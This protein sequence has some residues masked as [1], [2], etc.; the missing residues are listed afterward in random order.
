VL[1]RLRELNLARREVVKK[2][3]EV[4]ALITLGIAV[5]TLL[6]G[7][8]VYQQATGHSIFSR[9]REPIA[10]TVGQQP[11]LPSPRPTNSVTRGE[12]NSLHYG[13]VSVD[14]VNVCLEKIHEGPRPY[15]S[16]QAGDTIPTGSLIA[17]DFS[18]VGKQWTDFPI[19]PICHYGDW[20]LFE[21]TAQYIAPCEGAY[22][23]IIP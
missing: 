17:T 2:K 18:R 8:N 3:N 4:I 11:S 5:L 23:Y 9:A 15:I 7:D 12:V 20:G 19:V 13:E 1:E 22:W 21:S 6:V 14:Q 10:P 16:F